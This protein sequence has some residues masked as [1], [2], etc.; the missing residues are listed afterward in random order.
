MEAVL[1]PQVLVGTECRCEIRLRNAGSTPVH[2]VVLEEEIPTSANYL[3]SEPPAQVHERRLRWDVGTV[4]AGAEKRYLVRLVPLQEGELRLKPTVTYSYGVEKVVQATRPRLQV[5]VRGPERCR[6]GEEAVFSIHLHNSGS[7]P[8]QQLVVQAQLS[9]GLRHAHGTTIEAQLPTLA[10]GESQTLPLRVKA[11]AAGPQ[12]CRLVVVALAHAEVTAQ[13]SLQVV[14]PRLELRLQGPP[15]CLVRSE[16]V[17]ELVLSNPGSA[18]T[19]PLALSVQVPDWLE[20]VQAG[21][22]GTYQAEQRC[23]VWQLPALG[24]GST[25]S[26]GLKLRAQAAG[27]GLLRAAVQT[28]TP[29]VVGAAALTTSPAAPPLQAKAE[30][31]VRAEGVPAIRFEVF[32]LEDPVPVGQEAVYEIRLLNQGTGPCTQVQLIALLPEGAEYKGS[33]GPTVVRQEGNRL[34]F[35][36]LAVLAVRNEAIY[37]IRVRGTVAGDARFRVQLSYDHM[38]AP[39]VKEESTQFIQP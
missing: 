9:E 8:A 35:A 38:R 15:R 30:L 24:A 37:R 3:G 31:A 25:R 5:H 12:W 7:G 21:E 11:T 32:D 39:V 1:P 23:V 18:E 26:I 34:I 28:V 33:S 2:R 29:H 4:E 13:A 22:G 19:E 36:P 6:V 17:Y 27:E 14:E 16:A 10:A 20:F